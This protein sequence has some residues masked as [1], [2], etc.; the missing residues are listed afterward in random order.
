MR[1]DPKDPLH[2][3]SRK[4]AAEVRLYCQTTRRVL[5]YPASVLVLYCHWAG[6]TNAKPLAWVGFV[7][8][9]WVWRRLIEPQKVLLGTTRRVL[10]DHQL[11]IY[12]TIAAAVV[13]WT[14]LGTIML[15]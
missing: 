15:F 3:F 12:A 9:F 5:V 11:P 2:H 7:G 6:A 13:P 4:A 10:K 8:L 1:Y 14:M